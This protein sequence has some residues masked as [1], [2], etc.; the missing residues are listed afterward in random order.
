MLSTQ[1]LQFGHKMGGDK[2][3]VNFFSIIKPRRVRLKND[4]KHSPVRPTFF[5]HTA[6]RFF[7]FLSGPSSVAG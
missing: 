7:F 1:F 5:L 3:S 6:Q 2:E 4:A